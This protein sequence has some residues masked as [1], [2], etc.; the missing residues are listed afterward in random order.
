MTS[1]FQ[2]VFGFRFQLSPRAAAAPAAAAFQEKYVF[3]NT[4]EDEEYEIVPPI[5]IRATVSK[6]VQGGRPAAIKAN[7]AAFKKVNAQLL[8]K[9]LKNIRAER[10]AAAA[11]AAVGEEEGNNS[12]LNFNLK[13]V[14]LRLLH[15]QPNNKSLTLK[16][17]KR[18]AAQLLQFNQDR[19][20]LA[21]S[22]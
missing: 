20:R 11:A 9:E 7:K 1:S 17:G 16:A 6:K 8:K 21:E 18:A 2:Q 15:H 4:P 10:G 12:R 22:L 3:V 13:K 14:G 19:K 5:Y